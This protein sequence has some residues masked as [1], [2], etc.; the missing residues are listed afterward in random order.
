MPSWPSVSSSPA[1]VWW[2]NYQVQFGMPAGYAAAS[3]RQVDSSATSGTN[4]DGSVSNVVVLAAGEN[5]TSIDS[6]FYK[7]AS[8]GDKVWADR[9]WTIE[10]GR[11]FVLRLQLKCNADRQQ[12]ITL[13]SPADSSIA[14]PRTYFA[15][16]GS[17][18]TS[19]QKRANAINM[20]GRS[21]ILLVNDLPS[22][23][24]GRKW[25]LVTFFDN[26]LMPM[27]GNAIR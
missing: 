17:R 25:R 2:L 14:L 19:I 24:W 20:P 4:S 27:D 3:P 26:S 9:R 22:I 11:E 12:K 5:N 1:S 6:G 21:F 16:D 18:V 15:T 23:Q 7:L 10:T 8:I 13:N